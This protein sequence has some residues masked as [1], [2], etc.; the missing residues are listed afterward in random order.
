VGR[1]IIADASFSRGVP[2]A[3]SRQHSQRLSVEF[4]GLH[5]IAME[6]VADCRLKAI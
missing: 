1:R 6:T 2:P 5:L 3:R 4:D